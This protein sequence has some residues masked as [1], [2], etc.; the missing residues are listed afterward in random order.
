[1]KIIIPM[2]GLGSRFATEG[3]EDIKP[4][5]KVQGRPM[6]EWIIS[7]FPG[8]TDFV[9]I[10]RD[11][12]LENTPL[13]Q[14]LTALCPTGEIIA[15]EP[16]KK[17]PVY[18]LSKAFDVVDDNEPVIVTYCDYYMTWDYVAFQRG[19]TNHPCSGALPCYTGF[20]PHLLHK[21]NLYAS[22]KVDEN[23][24]LIEIREKFSW[25]EDKEQS[26]H[27]P[28]LFYFSTAAIMKKYCQNMIDKDIALNG[29]YYVSLVYNQMVADGHHIW[30]P[31]DVPY[32][33]QWGTPKDLEEFNFWN[34]HISGWAK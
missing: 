15:I 24:N 29:E 28:G 16:H 14:V 5:I 9:F 21:E 33:C 11:E 12:H 22:C 30:I 23:D 26:L 4:L 32:F 10:C 25:T 6:I 27:S 7:M 18:A 19:L 1:M 17:G 13:R 34:Q 8:E 2:S 31:N 20:H 3:Y